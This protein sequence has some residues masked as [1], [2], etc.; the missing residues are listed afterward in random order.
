[1]SWATTPATGWAAGMSS[2]RRRMRYRAEDSEVRFGTT[3]L[4]KR[5]RVPT[6]EA[7]GPA[8]TFLRSKQARDVSGSRPRAFGA[9]EHNL[10]VETAARGAVCDYEKA[11]GR[12]P[13]QMA[14]THP[15]YDIVSHDPLTREDRHI[16]VKGVT[17]EWNQTGV[18][19]SK[20]QFS[21][22]QDYGDRYWLYVSSSLWIP[23]IDISTPSK[24]P[25]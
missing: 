11:R 9:S 8:S 15:G 2:A 6:Q 18:G 23:N 5:K 1:M 16:E 7:M 12:F 22:A 3:D 4:G 25:P 21:N 13:E 17:G 19:L 10:A 14:Q 24:T 20:L